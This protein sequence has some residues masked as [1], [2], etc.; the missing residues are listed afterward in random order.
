MLFFVDANSLFLENVIRKTSSARTVI[1][2]KPPPIGSAIPSAVLSIEG[3][4]WA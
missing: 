4:D 3:V 1:V 2:K